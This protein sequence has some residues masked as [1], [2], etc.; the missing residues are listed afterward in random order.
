[1]NYTLGDFYKIW[2][3]ALPPG[4]EVA[5]NGHEVSNPKSHVL[6]DGE[7]IKIDLP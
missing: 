4:A 6:H 2:G 1:M 7:Q 3:K 5:V